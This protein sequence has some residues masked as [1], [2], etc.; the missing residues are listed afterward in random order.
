MLWAFLVVWVLCGVFVLFKLRRNGW[1]F[2]RR[3]APGGAGARPGERYGRRPGTR[4][5]H[6]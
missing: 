5:P 1:K 4:R 3:I 2:P 6:L